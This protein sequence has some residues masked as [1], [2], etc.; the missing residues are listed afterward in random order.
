MC[1]SVCE[2]AATMLNRCCQIH[3]MLQH[4][5]FFDRESI[6]RMRVKINIINKLLL[7]LIFNCHENVNKVKDISLLK[8]Q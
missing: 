6:K 5:S 1:F 2:S 3:A 4:C 7:T 8:P